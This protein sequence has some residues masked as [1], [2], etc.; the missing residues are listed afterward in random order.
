MNCLN[1]TYRCKDPNTGTQMTLEGVNNSAFDAAVLCSAVQDKI[2]QRKSAKHSKTSNPSGKKGGSFFSRRSSIDT[3]SA[4]ASSSTPTASTASSSIRALCTAPSSIGVAVM[5]PPS[6]GGQHHT[7]Q[8]V[9]MP[10][11]LPI[12]QVHTLEFIV[13][14]FIGE[15]RMQRPR[16]R[17]I[18]FVFMPLTPMSRDQ[19]LVTLIRRLTLALL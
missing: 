17:I 10:N 8:L 11:F 16:I 9:P 19:V 13:M 12:H 15:V 2:K 6:S 18:G 14:M 5:V 4:S 3:S 7:L 1:L